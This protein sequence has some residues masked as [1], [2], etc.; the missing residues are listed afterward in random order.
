VSKLDVRERKLIKAGHQVWRWYKEEQRKPTGEMS[1]T[2]AALETIWAAK[3]AVR[4]KLM[5]ERDAKA[6]KLREAFRKHA[7]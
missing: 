3:R 4:Q 2:D 5:A 1:A 6:V 7:A